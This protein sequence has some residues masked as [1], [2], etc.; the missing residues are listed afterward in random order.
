MKKQVNRS[1]VILAR[2][3]RRQRV[4]RFVTRRIVPM[5]LALTLIFVFSITGKAADKKQ[6]INFK[7]FTNVCVAPG[8]DLEDLAVDYCKA[9]IDLDDYLSEVRSINHL[10]AE[11]DVTPGD[12][13]ILPYYSEEFK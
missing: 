4:R 13:L 11:E 8:Q 1:R 5:I 6:N 7:Y 3:K 10:E 2:A 12:Y 9:D